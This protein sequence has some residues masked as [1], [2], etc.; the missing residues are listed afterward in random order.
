MYPFAQDCYLVAATTD[1][2]YSQK[3]C[4]LRVDVHAYCWIGCAHRLDW[5]QHGS[6]S[7]RTH[8]ACV[9]HCRLSKAG[10]AESS[11]CRLRDHF[12]ILQ[13]CRAAQGFRFEY[14]ADMA[15]SVWPE[16]NEQTIWS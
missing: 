6:A 13:V 8:L 5:Q 11:H 16:H 10:A 14:D 15:P 3:A 1:A 7:N 12:A 4:S 2:A 9:L